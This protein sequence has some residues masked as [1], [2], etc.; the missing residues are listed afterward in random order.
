MATISTTLPQD[1]ALS[2][3]RL[4]AFL[5]G[6]LDPAESLLIVAHCHL[7]C[8]GRKRIIALTTCAAAAMETIEPQ[9]MRCSA[10]AFFE[11]KCAAHPKEKPAELIENA[12]CTKS[13]EVPKP[14]QPYLGTSYEAVDWTLL[15][16]G[17]F[18]K[19]V[20]IPGSRAR[21][22]FL[23][24]NKGTV[25]PEHR[26]LGDQLTLI[27]RGAWIDEGETYRAGDVSIHQGD[28]KNTFTP[29]AP[30]TQ[31]E[32]CICMTVLHGPVKLIGIMA[33]IIG[34]FSMLFRKR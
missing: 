33:N 5:Q 24:I 13:C 1:K 18:S 26:H 30:V 17:I 20:S 9:T 25:I 22:R 8:E 14:L 31:G 23:K 32:D 34:L 12:H 7:S 15:Y 28:T 29:H 2:D 4:W 19:D 6:E 10:H 3:E 21:T 11:E 27:L 16:P